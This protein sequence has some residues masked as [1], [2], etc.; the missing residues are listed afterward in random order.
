LRH[1]AQSFKIQKETL[2]FS[3]SAGSTE[4]LNPKM[5]KKIKKRLK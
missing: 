1:V 2:N 5:K 3:S 4:N